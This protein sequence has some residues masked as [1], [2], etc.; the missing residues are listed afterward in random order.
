MKNFFLLSLFLSISYFIFGQEIADGNNDSPS[1]KKGK[2]L[3]VRIASDSIM[4]ITPMVIDEYGRAKVLYRKGKIEKNIGWGLFVAAPAAIIAGWFVHPI[5]VYWQFK[6]LAG[7]SAAS[8]CVLIPVGYVH[9]ARGLRKT[10]NIIK[11]YGPMPQA[12]G[13]SI[14]IA[15][16]VFLCDAPRISGNMPMGMTLSLDF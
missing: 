8:S 10:N 11:H 6:V 4:P 3:S 16:S 1:E 14:R 15:P 9:K 5:H 12:D 2:Q 13:V 7:I